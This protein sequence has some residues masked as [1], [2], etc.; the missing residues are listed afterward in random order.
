MIRKIAT[1]GMI[2]AEEIMITIDVYIK[3]MTQTNITAE[4]IIGEITL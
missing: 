1:G 2:K 3:E 4:F